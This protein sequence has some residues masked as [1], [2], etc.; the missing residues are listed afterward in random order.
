MRSTHSCHELLSSFAGDIV[1]KRWSV[2]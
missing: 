1:V 2:V